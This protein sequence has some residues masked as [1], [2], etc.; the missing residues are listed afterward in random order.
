MKITQRRIDKDTFDVYGDG[1]LLGTAT[2]IASP[3]YGLTD[4]WSWALEADS[5]VRLI[6]G[7]P[8]QRNFGRCETLKE[9]TVNIA[10]W[11][12]PPTPPTPVTPRY[13]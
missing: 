8:S 10:G 2:R 9:A 4:N 12:Q 11:A 13:R 1:T 5:R 3:R 6:S 7:W